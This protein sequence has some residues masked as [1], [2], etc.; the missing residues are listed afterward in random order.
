MKFKYISI[1]VR[2]LTNFLST[3]NHRTIRPFTTMST[4]KQE[5][6]L[7]CDYLVVG[8]GAAPLAFIDTLL[9]ELPESKI[10]LID[11]KEAPGGHWVDAYGFVRLHQPSLVYGLASKQLE[12]NWGSLMFKKFMLPWK[13]RAN[14]QEMLTY[15]SD[16]VNEKVASQQMDFYPN[17]V[18]NFEKSENDPSCLDTD[19]HRF[20]YF[21]SVDGSVS[22]KVKVNVKLIDGT[23]GRCIIPHGTIQNFDFFDY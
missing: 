17:S 21:S 13:H 10:I 15:F 7:E 20:H 5:T 3:S 8:A 18:F 9:T 2:Q 19:E 4:T 6:L 12:G 23:H 22:Y 1:F 14:K 11:K 16:F